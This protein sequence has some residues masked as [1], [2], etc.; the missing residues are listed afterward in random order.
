MEL[1]ATKMPQAVVHLDCT[2]EQQQPHPPP[3]L[4]AGKQQK[5]RPHTAPSASASRTRGSC[6]SS[7]KHAPHDACINDTIQEDRATHATLTDGDHTTH[8]GRRSSDRT[9]YTLRTKSA[10]QGEGRVC[11]ANPARRAVARPFS[12]QPRCRRDHSRADLAAQHPTEPSSSSASRSTSAVSRCQDRAL[13]RYLAWPATANGGGGHGRGDGPP[14]SA[15]Q[16]HSGT[17][18]VEGSLNQ[19]P[20]CVDARMLGE[21]APIQD[22]ELSCA[23]LA[24]TSVACTS[25]HTF[26]PAP[27]L[28]TEQT[29]LSMSSRHRQSERLT[30]GGERGT[31]A[32]E[33]AR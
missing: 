26:H 20:G 11:S 6:S 9:E 4:P 28:G 33:H 29:T 10:L 18:S 14:P 24:L 5:Q 8:A 32:V 23:S 30:G 2:P 15:C 22:V 7:A 31:A 3:Q 19:K 13:S 1:C 16:Q 17:P 21:T 25:T 12:C 27:D